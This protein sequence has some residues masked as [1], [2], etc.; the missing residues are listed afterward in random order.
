M[1]P[2]FHFEHVPMHL[3]STNGVLVRST[4]TRSLFA[5]IIGQVTRLTLGG[6]S[7]LCWKTPRDLIE[8]KKKI[9]NERNQNIIVSG[10]AKNVSLWNEKG[11]KTFVILS[12]FRTGHGLLAESKLSTSVGQSR[13]WTDKVSQDLC[14]RILELDFG[15]TRISVEPIR[16]W[17]DYILGRLSFWADYLV[18][19]LLG[20]VWPDC[21]VR[22]MGQL[23]LTTP[24]QTYRVIGQQ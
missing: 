17:T 15:P 20:V 19:G 24:I 11:G 3:V 6:Q 18:L 13:F 16:F 7:N 14:V 22:V 2:L 23:C 5:A 10:G 4:W 12:W 1:S 8:K 21:C 9:K